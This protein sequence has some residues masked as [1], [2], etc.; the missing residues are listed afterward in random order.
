MAINVYGVLIGENLKE[1]GFLGNSEKE[2]KKYAAKYAASCGESPLVCIEEWRESPKGK[3]YVRICKE[4][5]C[6]QDILNFTDKPVKFKDGY[7]SEVEGTYDPYAAKVWEL[8][9]D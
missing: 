4:H 7:L 9:E 8:L 1:F 2:V 6:L 3:G 5:P